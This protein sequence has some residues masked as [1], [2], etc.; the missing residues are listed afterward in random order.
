MPPPTAKGKRL[1]TSANM[2]KPAKEKQY[3]K[4]SK[5]KGL[6][7]LSEVALTKAEQMKLATKKSLTQ[8]HISHASGS[9]VDEGTS[10]IPGVPD[11]PTYESD[12]EEISWKSSK[13]DDEEVNISEHDDDVDNQSDDD[14]QN[15]DDEQTN[16]DND[17]DNFVHPKFS[18]YDEE[19]K[20]EERFDP[21]VQTPS[22]VK[23]T[24]DEDSYGMNVEGDEGENED[25]DGNELYGDLNINLECRDIQMV[26]VQTTQV[27]EDTHVTLTP[28]NPEDVPV[29]TTAEPS[30]LSVTTFPSPSLL[31]ISH[32]QQIPAPSP[33]NI[34]SSSLQEIPNFGSLF[35]FDHRLKAL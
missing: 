13:D 20:D 26:D 35:R 8:T 2:D 5:A 15:D 6:T 1:K 9:V 32:V 10:I 19:D 12:D 7:V 25:D 31:I 34:P 17:S 27:I 4:T 16:S 21:I 3:A 33:T 22:Q 30:L 23:N 11:V 14:D 28:V 18:T 29:M 24:Y